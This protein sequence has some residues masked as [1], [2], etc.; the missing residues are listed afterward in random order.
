MPDR[1][2]LE[3]PFLENRHRELA[4]RIE[5]WA[6]DALSADGCETDVDVDETCRGL[7]ARLAEGNWLSHCVADAE[8]SGPSRLDVR[9]LC[10]LREHLARHSALADFAFAMQGQGV[11]VLS[12]KE[13]LDATGRRFNTGKEDP[14]AAEFARRFTKEFPALAKKYPVYAELQNIF[15]NRIVCGNLLQPGIKFFVFPLKMRQQAGFGRHN[16]QW[17]IHP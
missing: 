5:D 7:V 12:E 10:L 16:F 6:R 14:L 15:D 8:P 9:S 13:L 1:S 4:R 3:W 17:I 11:K 2:Y